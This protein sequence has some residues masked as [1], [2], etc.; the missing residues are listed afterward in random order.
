MRLTTHLLRHENHFELRHATMPTYIV[1]YLFPV[2]LLFYE[3][4]RVGSWIS[5][6]GMNFANFSSMGY[7]YTVMLAWFGLQVTI[8]IVFLI[9][10]ALSRHHDFGHRIANLLCGVFCSAVVLLFDF[11]LQHWM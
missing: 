3:V 9:G 11:G 7:E 4:W 6:H 1:S 5:G 2:V 10:A 8:E